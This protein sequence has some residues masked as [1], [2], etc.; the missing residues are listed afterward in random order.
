MHQKNLS[1]FSYLLKYL[2]DIDIMVHKTNTFI[3]VINLQTFVSSILNDLI[4]QFLLIIS[5]FH[6]A[7]KKMKRIEY[8]MHKHIFQL[9]Y[10]LV[11]VLQLS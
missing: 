6:L 1:K 10:S 11:H 2:S 3:T 4:N 7:L 9:L 8:V 5:S